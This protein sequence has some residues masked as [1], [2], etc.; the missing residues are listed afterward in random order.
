MKS[1]NINNDKNFD[2]DQFNVRYQ[3][4]NDFFC[5][6]IDLVPPNIYLNSDDRS[7]WLNLVTNEAKKRKQ[8][9]KTESSDNKSDSKLD[10]DVNG[11]ENGN[12][13]DDLYYERTSKFDPILFKTVSQIL[14]DMERFNQNKKTIQ[15]KQIKPNATKNDTSI[16]VLNKSQNKSKK[17]KNEN[18]TENKV[19]NGTDNDDDDDGDDEKEEKP[20]RSREKSAQK[21]VSKGKDEKNEAIKRKRQRYD[22]QSEP[23]IVNIDHTDAN[24]NSKAQ[25]P[26]LN[27]NGE[28]V[29]SKFDFTADKTLVKNK[30]KDEKLTITNAKPKDY[31]KLLKQLQEKREKVEQLKQVEPEKANEIEMKSKW[32]SAIDKASG[33][34]VKDDIGMLKKA[35]KKIEKKKEKSRKNWEERKK[36]VEMKKNKVQD[37]R[38]K[39]IEKR[40]QKKKENK[41]KKLRKKGRILPGF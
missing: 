9:N 8:K 32:K 10:M 36:E 5:S 1:S 23:Q 2:I 18:G 37:K 24:S 4:N 19:E 30:S 16:K 25:K 39:N 35:V 14:K 26:I 7:N 31:K 41:M 40:K 17:S 34:K 27:N 15:F 28:I 29:F 38:N 22:S 33:L 12:D 21:R 20:A 6:F 11:Y 13:E 3:K